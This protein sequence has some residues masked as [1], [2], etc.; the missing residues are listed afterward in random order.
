M[1]VELMTLTST[2]NSLLLPS[3]LIVFSTKNFN[4]LPCKS[5]GISATSS[6]NLKIQGLRTDAAG[7]A[8]LSLTLFGKNSTGRTISA[9]VTLAQNSVSTADTDLTDLREKIKT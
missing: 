3:R 8:T 9:G 2:S 5:K 4:I 6:T 7:S 1:F